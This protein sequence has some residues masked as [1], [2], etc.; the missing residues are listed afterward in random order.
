MKIIPILATVR[1]SVSWLT[2]PFSALY[3]QRALLELALLA[4]PAGAL[5]AFVVLRRLAFFTHA[6]GVGT[7]PG[8]VVAA[9][10]GVSV[11]GG[12]LVSA[13]V[14]ALGLAALQRRRDLDPAAATGLLLAGALALGSLLVSNVFGSSAQVDT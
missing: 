6:L 11:F 12:G 4:I 10:I 14:L 8:V 13:L 2:D 1:E 7:F 9:G 3:M 5:G